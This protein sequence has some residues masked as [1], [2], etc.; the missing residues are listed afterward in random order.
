MRDVPH[1]GGDMNSALKYALTRAGLTVVDVAALL[2]VDPKTVD[3]WI[4]GRVPHRGS[5]VKLADLVGVPEGELWPGV[6]LRSLGKGPGGSEV[7]AAYPHR[8]NVAPDVWRSFFARAEKEVGLLV[9]SGLFLLEDSGI[10]RILADKAAAG[11]KV[12]LLLGDPSSGHVAIRGAEEGIRDAMAA[13]IRNAVVLLRPLT[14]VAGVEIR[15]HGTTL[16]NSIF[17]SDDELL[18]NMHVYGQPAAHSPVLHLR[19][20]DDPA[21]TSTYLECFERVWA[22]ARSP[23]G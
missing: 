17:R 3:R 23:E 11:A 8:W 16:Y 19:R 10:L 1:M 5:R 13:R 7:R 15:M 4:A 2:G 6:A 21:M 20:T 14:S 18:I 9:Y 22:E 12:R